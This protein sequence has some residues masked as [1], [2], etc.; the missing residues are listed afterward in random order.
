MKNFKPLL[1]ALVG[2]TCLALPQSASAEAFEGEYLG[3]GAGV[4]IVKTTG[5]AAGTPISDSLTKPMAMLIAGYRAPLGSESPLVLGIEGD[6]GATIDEFDSRIGISGI[7]GVRAGENT[8]VYARAGYASRS[9][10]STGTADRSVDGLMAGAGVEFAALE[11]ANLR[12]DYRYADL[13]SSTDILST[14][15]SF[16]GHEANV[17]LIFDF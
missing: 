16:K 12:L 15:R 14:T 11:W 4:S 9:G 7:V 8:L 17:A 10:I 6:F 13:G 1:A 3:V 5:D 2:A